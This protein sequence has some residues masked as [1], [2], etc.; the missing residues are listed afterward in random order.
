MNRY[1]KNLIEDGYIGG[2]DVTGTG[3][4]RNHLGLG[5]RFNRPF[6]SVAPLND[7]DYV[8]QRTNE[9]GERIGLFAKDTHKGNDFSHVLKGYH[10]TAIAKDI[11]RVKRKRG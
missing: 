6:G 5:Y 3:N 2:K 4:K 8:A 11:A 10:Q 7:Y 9:K 1:D